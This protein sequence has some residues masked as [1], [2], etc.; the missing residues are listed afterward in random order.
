MT[1]TG[2]CPRQRKSSSACGTQKFQIY[3][4]DKETSNYIYSGF[5]LNNIISYYYLAKL[6]RAL[7]KYEQPAI[8]AT[9]GTAL[10][11]GN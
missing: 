2:F 7:M 5:F 11:Y 9:A 8:F 1:I 10:F 4:Y 6:I 3:D